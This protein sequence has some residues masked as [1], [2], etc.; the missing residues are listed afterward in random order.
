MLSLTNTISFGR[1]IDRRYTIPFTLEYTLSNGQTKTITDMAKYAYSPNEQGR[2]NYV[3]PDVDIENGVYIT[4]LKLRLPSDL[5]WGNNAQKYGK[6]PAENSK[7]ILPDIGLAMYN[8]PIPKKYPGTNDKIGSVSDHESDDSYDKLTVKAK[9]SFEDVFG[10]NTTLNATG[11]SERIAAQRVVVDHM[12]LS[13]STV[14]PIPIRV[15]SYR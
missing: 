3:I 15:M 8:V 6:D 4:N 1:L 7:R 2:M 12:G 9:L 5:N 10:T 11:T 14:P 13:V